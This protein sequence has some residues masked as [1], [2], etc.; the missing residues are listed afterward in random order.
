MY[1]NEEARAYNKALTFA[2]RKVDGWPITPGELIG[3]RTPKEVR[4]KL[5]QTQKNM[6][7][8]IS[9]ELRADFMDAGDDKEGS[10]AT[11]PRQDTSSEPIH[12][13]PP[14]EG[15]QPPVEPSG[16]GGDGSGDVHGV[17]SN[18]PR[19]DLFRAEGEQ[20]SYHLRLPGQE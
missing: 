10:H 13:R 12:Q 6:L 11:V 9:M 5:A 4:V 14:P 8:A 3:P 15:P 19:D 1:S 17:R 16:T 2:I 20:R 7:R 18:E